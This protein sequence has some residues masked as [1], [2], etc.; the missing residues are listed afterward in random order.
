MPGAS[1]GNGLRRC[2]E[3]RARPL[4]FGGDLF[5][6]GLVVRDQAVAAD[7]AA[8]GS[9]GLGVDRKPRERRAQQGDG[10]K[11]G[12][13]MPVRTHQGGALAKKVDQTPTG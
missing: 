9:P 8:G 3:G 5:A 10:E 6:P 7:R 13:H 1:R 11:E 2:P 12:F 4:A